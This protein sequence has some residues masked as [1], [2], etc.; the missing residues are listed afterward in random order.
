[1]SFDINSLIGYVFPTT[2]GTSIISGRPIIDY[3][4]SDIVNNNYAIS[5]IGTA[6]TTWIGIEL[7]NLNTTN[8]ENGAYGTVDIYGINTAG[9]AVLWGSGFSIIGFTSNGILLGKNFVSET[10]QW[11]NLAYISEVPITRGETYSPELIAYN[12]PDTAGFTLSCFLAGTRILTSAG[13]VPVEQ[14]AVGDLVVTASGAVRPV[15]WVGARGLDCARHRDPERV[16]PVRISAGA[17]A[18]NVP[19]RDLFLSPDHAVFCKGAAADGAQDVLIP[20]QDLINGTTIAQIPAG[21]VTYHH[22]ELARHDLLLA[23]GLAVES[24]LET[25]NRAVFGGVGPAL[26]L[27]PDFGA[28]RWEAAGYAPLVVTGPLCDA[29]R[30][31]LARRAIALATLDR[32]AA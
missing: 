2:Y 31:R 20:V 1:M 32:A 25:G 26:P 24:Y 17:F 6:M 27:H 12:D 11:G 5:S 13:E 7:E 16:L 9:T 3:T 4:A 29:A 22:I 8:G 23:E 21:R 10:G 30:A 14:I 18:D 15:V 28:L 19:A